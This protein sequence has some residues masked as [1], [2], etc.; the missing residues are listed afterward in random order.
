MEFL[1]YIIA[2]IFIGIIAYVLVRTL[3]NDPVKQ[4]A[5]KVKRLQEELERLRANMHF[6]D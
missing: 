3:F 5:T 2:L 6:D 1:L 4:E